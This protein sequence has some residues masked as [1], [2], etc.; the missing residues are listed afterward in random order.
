MLTCSQLAQHR[1]STT[2]LP[3]APNA[4]CTCTRRAAARLR[5]GATAPGKAREGSPASQRPKFVAPPRDRMTA[6]SRRSHSCMFRGRG[7]KFQRP[8]LGFVCFLSGGARRQGSVSS[9]KKERCY[10]EI[11]RRR[12]PPEAAR[13]D[14]EGKKPRRRRKTIVARTLTYI[15]RPRC[16]VRPCI[17]GRY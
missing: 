9:R 14:H 7:S 15:E 11:M 12:R 2:S 3:N 4:Q 1:L 6:S 10:C 13:S 17:H 16:P 8:S 5:C